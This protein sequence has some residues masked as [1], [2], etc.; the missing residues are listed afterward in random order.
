MPLGEVNVDLRQVV[1]VLGKYLNDPVSAIYRVGAPVNV[2][3]GEDFVPG[4]T[5]GACLHDLV[6]CSVVLV[7]VVAQRDDRFDTVPLSRVLMLI[8]CD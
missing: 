5:L 1:S 8:R 4:V 3:K 6:K 2:P 7:S